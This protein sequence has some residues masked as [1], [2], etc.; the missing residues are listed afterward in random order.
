[1]N[2]YKTSENGGIPF[3]NDDHRWSDDSIRDYIDNHLSDLAVTIG[4]N[5][6]FYLSGAEITFNGGTGKYTIADGY[7]Y[8]NGEILKVDT[9]IYNLV[10]APNEYR[11][12]AVET[13]DTTGDKTTRSGSAIS[14]YRK[15]RA[16]P[17][18]YAIADAWTDDMLAFDLIADQ[19]RPQEKIDKLL[20]DVS[21]TE[22]NYITDAEKITESL[23]ALDVQLKI[24]SDNAILNTTVFEI[25]DWDMNASVTPV[26]QITHGVTFTK[27]RSVKVLIINDAANLIT[28]LTE[29]TSGAGSWYISSTEVVLSR[30][31]SGFYDS[32]N[33]ETPPSGNR[34]WVTIE[35]ED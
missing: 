35:Y 21:Y 11:I 30:A 3:V 26:A 17:T 22:Q 9:G 24:V 18:V 7:V 31:N 34:G 5:G 8:I 27:I 13:Y 25:G 20:G 28:G 16:V 32:T 12:I 1:M 10:I 6:N 29:Y 15:R 4:T 33:Y 2:Y 23:D 19:E 14:T